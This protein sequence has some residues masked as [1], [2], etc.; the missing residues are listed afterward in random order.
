MLHPFTNLHHIARRF[1]AD[2]HRLIH[3]EPANVPLQASQQTRLSLPGT[4]C[5]RFRS[6]ALNG[7]VDN[8]SSEAF[9]CCC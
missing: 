3:H 8:H 7:M 5:R 6:G 1:V 2:D 9:R 4:T